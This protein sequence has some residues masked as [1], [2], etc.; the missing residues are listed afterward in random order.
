MTI[1]FS[2]EARVLAKSVDR[3]H[4]PIVLLL[5]NIELL[6]RGELEPAID[7]AYLNIKDSL[8]YHASRPQCFLLSRLNYKDACI[9]DKR[10]HLMIQSLKLFNLG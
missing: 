6:S 8:T 9:V 4:L 3:Q 10:K 2:E 5:D 7:E 1:D